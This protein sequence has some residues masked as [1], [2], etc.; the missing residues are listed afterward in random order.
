MIN[1]EDEILL[2][3][4]LFTAIAECDSDDGYHTVWSTTVYDY[5]GN[6]DY[7][8]LTLVK[9]DGKRQLFTL[10]INNHVL[11]IDNERRAENIV[12]K[13]CRDFIIDYTDKYDLMAAPPRKFTVLIEETATGSVTVFAYDDEQ[14][15]KIAKKLYE[16]GEIQIDTLIENQ[17][18]TL[19][20]NGEEFSDW[21]SL[22]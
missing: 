4:F 2:G 1:K 3:D 6:K 9:T 5:K 12:L 11:H 16:N 14:A 7:C 8:Y 21:H 22:Y 18:N 10:D 17:I 13:E 20:E 15:E 19:D